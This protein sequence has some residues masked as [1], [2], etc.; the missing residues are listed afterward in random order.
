ML[1]VLI[2]NLIKLILVIK[3]MYLF[4]QFLK[5]KLMLST[6]ATLEIVK[7]ARLECYDRSVYL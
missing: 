4:R 5:K 1:P 7:F 3:E 2:K 6:K